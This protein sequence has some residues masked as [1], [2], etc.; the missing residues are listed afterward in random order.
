MAI[1]EILT[2]P[3][4]RLTKKSSDV[5]CVNDAI[6]SIIND[7]IETMYDAP[8]IGLAATQIG[9]LKNIVIV[10][11]CDKDEDSPLT[12]LVNPKITH[13]QGEASIEEGCLSVPN[14]L[15]KIKR[16]AEIVVRAFNADGDEVE[17]QCGGLLAIAV[18]HEID[19][20]SGILIVDYA[21]Y[22]K[23]NLYLKKI[24]KRELKK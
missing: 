4:P 22:L 6:K 16:A 9:I 2:Y 12:V 18:Q 11:S 13:A 7:M 15:V 24:K 14:L 19:H 10:D 3:D 5:A 8:G 1:R 21:S 17:L 20:L 23:R